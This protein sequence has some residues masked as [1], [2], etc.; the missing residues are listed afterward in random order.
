MA[1][2][3]DFYSNVTGISVSGTAADDTISIYGNHSTLTAGD[4]NDIILLHG[5]RNA[6]RYTEG[7]VEED[8]IFGEGGDDS[9]KV[10]SKGASIYGGTGKDTIRYDG[11]GG[12]YNDA[13]FYADGGADDDLL[14]L[15]TYAAYTNYEG[16]K[17]ITL[18]GGSG[19]D[20]IQ[21]DVNSGYRDYSKQVSFVVNDFSSDDTFKVTAGSN[22]SGK[23]ANVSLT[24]SGNDA[25][26]TDGANFT[27]TLKGAGNLANIGGAK[28]EV[29]STKKSFSEYFNIPDS[30]SD[31]DSDSDSDSDSDITLPAGITIADGVLTVAKTYA[32]NSVDVADYDGYDDDEIKIVNASAVVK[33]FSVI[34]NDEDNSISGGSKADTL[35]GGVGDDTLTGG[36]GADTFVHSE[37]DDVITDYVAGTDKIKLDDSEITGYEIEGKDVIFS[38]TNGSITVKNG[39]N[40][41][42]TIIDSE[43][44]TSKMA[45]SD[46][47]TVQAAPKGTSYDKNKT[48][49]IVKNGYTGDEVDISDY[50]TVVTVNASAVKSTNLT[51]NGNENNNSIRGGSG[52]DVLFGGTGKDTLY[53]G[54]GADTFV[55]SDGND[56]IADYVQGT[57]KIQLLN[58]EIVGTT[59]NGSDVVFTTDSG[60]LTV[61]NGKNKKITIV[62]ADGNDTTKT[63]G[64]TPNGLKYTNSNKLLKVTKDFIATDVDLAD[65]ADT[66]VTVDASAAS[67][68]VN[69]SGNKLNNKLIGSKYDD[70]LEGGEGSDYLDGGTRGT[71]YFIYTGGN[72]TIVGYTPNEDV[73]DIGELQIESV[74]YK[75][76]DAILKMEGGGS[77]RI[78]NAKN[79]YVT[80][81]QNDDEKKRY[82]GTSPDVQI[83]KTSSTK[84][85]T[86]LKG[87]EEDT[88]DL[89]DYEGYTRVTVDSK[90]DGDG[91]DII[92]TSKGNTL[93]GGK[94]DDTL[95]AGEGKN[96]LKGGSGDDVFVHSGGK[97]FIVDYQSG[98]K[99][100]FAEDNEIE[101]YKVS[102]S[103]VIFTTENGSV[104]VKGGKGKTIT[105]Q[106]GDDDETT[107]KYKS[108]S[109]VYSANVPEL[110]FDD[111]D[112]ASAASISDITAKNDFSVAEIENANLSALNKENV[113][114]TFAAK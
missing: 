31:A 76:N 10:E 80:F 50:S 90:Y 15:S 57:D 46:K 21:V 58:T 35:A 101:R 53:G 70:T 81:V 113:A 9:I 17:N 95:E 55:H 114:V 108:G 67:Q 7:D 61:K 2:G 11:L 25:V 99:I 103:N 56:T 87:F 104:T 6:P 18:S 75:V 68:P 47:A 13:N 12:K 19:K 63:Y 20:T 29:G 26:L 34:G 92:G 5:G 28:I 112:V 105:L 42:I 97:D 83:K 65:F 82:M 22:D 74:S 24:S 91:V 27:A 109:G 40:K 107:V 71:D 54:K 85:I 44:V 73:I 3:S 14:Y 37:G 33:K 102:G 48:V 16:K 36:A 110:W 66:V 93:V 88:L 72:D 32:G 86:I 4:G 96:S 39:N 45:Y 106:N 89:A 51:I 69:I 30:D 78:K 64:V 98:D 23:L 38:T 77:I 62:D 84:T 94:G 43:G 100:I 41:K 49:L 52:D 1:K 8:V 79:K 60:S 111:N 59:L